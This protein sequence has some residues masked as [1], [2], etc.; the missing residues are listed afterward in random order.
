MERGAQRPKIWLFSLKVY[1]ILTRAGMTGPLA[2]KS[3]LKL[4]SVPVAFGIRTLLYPGKARPV[5]AS[6]VHWP[7]ATG[8]K[9]NNPETTRIK[10]EIFMGKEIDSIIKLDLYSNTTNYCA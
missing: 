9:R 10:I 1:P 7:L 8:M 4:K 6:M 3:F 2:S 5:S